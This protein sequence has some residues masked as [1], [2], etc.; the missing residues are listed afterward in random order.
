MQAH[1]FADHLVP[2]KSMLTIFSICSNETYSKFKDLA[3]N[4]FKAVFSVPDD[5]N[6]QRLS[7]CEYGYI[8]VTEQA[9][10]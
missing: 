5:N 3:D 1:S 4:S 6:V 10:P 2:T 7:Y 9:L 8:L